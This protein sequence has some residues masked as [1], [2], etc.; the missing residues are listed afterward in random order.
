M[1]A[2]FWSFW[3]YIIKKKGFERDFMNSLLEQAKNFYIAA[4]TSPV[5]S[6]PLLYYYS[7]LNL[8]KLIINLEKEYGHANYLHGMEA[9]H[10]NRFSHSVVKIVPLKADI[11]NVTA[12]LLSVLDAQEMKSM[13]VKNLR[14][15]LRHCVGIHRAYS[16][17]YNLDEV[18]HR[19]TKR[20][21]YREGKRLGVRF[22]VYCQE[23]DLPL[24]QLRGYDI[25][26]VDHCYYWKVEVEM[27]SYTPSRGAF[28]ELSSRLRAIGVW[29]FLGAD[30][31][32]L[33]I[34]SQKSYRESPEMIIYNTM[35][36]LGSITR[37]HPY[38]YDKIFSDK[39]QW[40]M[41]EFLTTQPKQF[42]YLASAKVLGQEILKSYSSL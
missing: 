3:D 39:E 25:E 33:Y 15:Y 12:E 5:R 26:E 8:S 14:K 6:K 1:V 30:G 23:K 28:F 37:Y 18:F 22:Q 7:F 16:E 2:D 24:L 21:I 13:D 11:K 4:E 42:L 17:I 19:L 38:M 32:S 20:K 41:S 10:N 29:Y 36:F 34:S 35:F 40:L 31:Y 9:K 27:N